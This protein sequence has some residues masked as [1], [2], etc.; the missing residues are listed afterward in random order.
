MSLIPTTGWA[1][2]LLASGIVDEQPAGRR[3]CFSVLSILSGM[4][5]E[6][7][8]SWIWSGPDT[9]LGPEESHNTS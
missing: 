4:G 7:E 2:V 3:V 9:L 6:P 8:A 1:M 5:V